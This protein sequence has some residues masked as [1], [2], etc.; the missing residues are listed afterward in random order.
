MEKKFNKY[1]KKVLA[2]YG[3]KTVIDLRVKLQ[4][5]EQ[6]SKNTTVNMC[7][8]NKENESKKRLFLISRG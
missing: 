4:G 7:E 2:L 3:V 5:V 1:W 8:N 6:L